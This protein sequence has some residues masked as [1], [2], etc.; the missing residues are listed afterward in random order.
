MQDVRTCT[1]LARDLLRRLA[2]IIGFSH[3]PS[4]IQYSSGLS[5]LSSGAIPPEGFPSRW[6][7]R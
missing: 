7:G 1:K 3:V 4:M 5:M 2:W 6:M